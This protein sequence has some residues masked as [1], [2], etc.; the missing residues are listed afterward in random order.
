[1]IPAWK[2]ARLLLIA[3][4]MG[5]LGIILAIWLALQPPW[6]GLDLRAS[7]QASGGVD[8]VGVTPHGPAAALQPGRLLALGHGGQRLEL[9]A[10]DLT[11]DPDQL[12]SYAE[13]R[14]FFQRQTEISNMLAGATLQLVWQGADGDIHDTRVTPEPRPLGALPGLL[15]FEF[16]CALGGG[17]IASWVFVLRPQD[18]A[19]R[20][21]AVTG[22]TMFVAIS[23]N[24]VYVNREL[25]MSGDLLHGLDI[26]N[27]GAAFLYGCALIDLLLCYPQPLLAPRHLLWAPV[28]FVPW[29]LLDAVGMWPDQ[30]WGVDL[31]LIVQI[32]I[33]SLLSGVHW[34]RSRR[35]PLARAALRWFLLSFLLSSWLFV[36][37]TI[38]PM[39]LGQPAL[40]P[41]G[42]AAGFLLLI[43]LSLALGI[44]RYRI[45]ELDQWSYRI[46]LTV[47]SAVAVA[48]LDLLLVW[49]LHLDPLFSLGWALF[50]GGWL[51]FPFRQWLW[52]RMAGRPVA[53]LEV[54]LPDLIGIAFT[55][56]AEGREQR[57]QHLLRRLFEPLLVA[58]HNATLAY[59]QLADDGLALQIPACGGLQARELRYAGQGKRLF[60][61]RDV[62]F[63]QALCTLLAEAAANRDAYERGASEERRRVYSDLHDDIGAKL[64]S[65]VVGAESPQRADTARAALQ[66]LRDVVTHSSRDPVPL[67]EWLADWRAEME[68]RLSAAGLNLVWR[69][70]FD[71]PLVVVAP[72]TAM[73]LGR[74]LREGASNVLRHAQASTLT[75]A[76]QSLSGEL[77]ISMT[78]DGRGLPEPIQRPGKGLINMRKRA[79]QLGGG[80]VWQSAQPRGCEV[81]L[82]V[83]L[84]KIGEE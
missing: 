60:N 22:W 23:V 19:A 32:L 4:L 28:V 46:L 74:I 38:G 45:F 21:F 53:Q 72:P 34:H 16:A 63:A 31:P 24:A 76:I 48:G 26:L 77:D 30:A 59:S 68:G 13:V 37:T 8:I 56:S 36:F 29:W 83:A 84:A 69:Q 39:L 58:A 41:I 27:H 35:Q 7:A 57:W 78:D 14:R 70:A 66:D 1:M 61:P 80:I 52:Q 67:S 73:H 42:Y 20:L 54:V 12:T 62:A 71:L 2:P 25:A 79:E 44:S 9:D 17:L 49:I 75:V 18:L 51:Y 33:V 47:V 82:R 81:R 55:V 64:L 65:L 6:L 11:P 43:Y 5:L 3:T 40:I 10:L 50:I 15:W